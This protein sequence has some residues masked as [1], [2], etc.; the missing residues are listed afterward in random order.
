[1]YTSNDLL[2]AVKDVNSTTDDTDLEEFAGLAPGT[3][4]EFI[5]AAVVPMS[6]DEATFMLTGVIVALRA[7]KNGSNSD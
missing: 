5:N 6:E 1:M 4:E 3:L 7:V 2:E